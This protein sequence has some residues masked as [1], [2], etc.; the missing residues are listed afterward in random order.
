MPGLLV[1]D[2]RAEGELTRWL[3]RCRRPVEPSAGASNS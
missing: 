1:R 3:T 2:F